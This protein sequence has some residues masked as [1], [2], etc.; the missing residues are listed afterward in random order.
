MEGLRFCPACKVGFAHPAGSAGDYYPEYYGELGPFSRA[1]QERWLSAKRRRIE[2]LV[3]R[4]RVLD[5][6]CGSGAFLRVLQEAGW[7]V[8]GVEPMEAARA[9]LC[10]PLRGKVHPS[11]EAAE[12][13]G[14]RFDAVTLWHS[15]EHVPDPGGAL[16]RLGGLLRG[17]GALYAAVPNFESLERRIG[18]TQWF[19]LDIPRHR[20][21]FTPEG[22][23]RALSDAGFAVESVRQRAF[24]YD[25]F[26]LLQ[27]LLNKATG[28]RDF[29]YDELKRGGSMRR[30]WSRFRRAGAW[31]RTLTA[32]PFI[33]P[34]ALAAVPLLQALGIS[35][36]VEAAAR[37]KP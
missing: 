11:L 5:F 25:S 34:A 15:L 29:L 37:K 8:R 12:E 16:R 9:R 36:S 33:L 18:G 32:A 6:G 14:L 19:S 31:V 3:P 24:T 28:D 17:G 1:L 4:G 30:S 22:L 10:A 2:S 35:G 23:A 13:E 20:T 21:H 27:T 26:A 7:D